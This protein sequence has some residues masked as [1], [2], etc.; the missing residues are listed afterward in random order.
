VGKR[1]GKSLP[2]TAGGHP[3][4]GLALGGGAARGWAHLGVIRALAEAGIEPQVISGTSMGAIIGALVASGRFEAAR[5]EI[6]SADLPKVVSYVD[7]RILGSGLIDGWRVYRLLRAWFGL[8]DIEGLARKFCAVATDL[9]SGEEVV[10]RSGS[11]ASAVRASISIPGVFSP[12]FREG[13]WLVD[14]GL[15]DPVPC[16]PARAMGAEF[17][18]AVDLNR[19]LPTSTISLG[20]PRKLRHGR[21]QAVTSGGE[22]PEAPADGHE[23]GFLSVLVN[24]LL[25]GH[26]MLSVLRAT[27]EPPDLLISP[28]LSAF[29][30]TEFHRAAELA[31]AGYAAAVERLSP[32]AGKL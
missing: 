4:V 14:G 5:E 19:S 22:Q 8:A 29:S 1:D 24:S 32:I 6:L 16:G 31:E 27:V 15:V 12:W 21:L 3:V 28:D 10:M 18:I 11:L 26:S 9:S 2:R 23:P 13:R 7:P 20:P 17:V 30:G 25:I